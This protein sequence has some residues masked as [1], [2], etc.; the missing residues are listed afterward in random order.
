MSRI[1]TTKAGDVLDAI[2]HG[3]YGRSAGI[4]EAV[5][6]A[7]RGDGLADRGPVLPAGVVIVLPDIPDAVE[8]PRKLVRLWD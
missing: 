5:L 2:V 1:Y 7:N 8:P 6:E 3:A 4:T